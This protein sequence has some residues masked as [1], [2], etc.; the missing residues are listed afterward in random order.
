MNEEYCFFPDLADPDPVYHF[1]G[2]TFGTFEHEVVVTDEQCAAY[3]EEA[4][5]LYLEVHPEYE[6]TIRSIL[7]SGA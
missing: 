6:G 4:C 5:A 3:L 7:A 2:V 1:S